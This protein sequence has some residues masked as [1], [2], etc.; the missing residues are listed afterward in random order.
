MTMFR[1]IKDLFSSD[2]WS[3]STAGRV[4]EMLDLCGSMYDYAQAVL[5]AGQDDS[6]VQARIYDRDKRINILECEVRRSVVTHLALDH[7]SHD[8]PTAL[9]FMNVVKDAERIGDYIKNLYDVSRDLLP[10]GFDKALIETYLRDDSSTIENLLGRT[11][12]AFRVSDEAESHAII[13]DARQL[14]VHIESS[15][16]EV[17][18]SDMAVC[19]A[20]SLVL[21]LRFLKR[22]AG[23]LSN[24]ASS[25]VMPV[26][27]M[28]FYDEPEAP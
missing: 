21:V 17:S 8:I 16:I 9:I 5:L 10:C 1:S 12:K 24:I 11:T 14:G 4:G 22:I 3:Q 25:V 20:V 7:R 26:D 18:N 28:D 6:K 27:Q 13:D 19:S 23:H 2:N 15:I